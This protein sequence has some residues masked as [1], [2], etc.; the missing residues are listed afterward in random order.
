[1]SHIQPL[2]NA[3]FVDGPAK[4]LWKV[5]RSFWVK[6][7]PFNP[8]I[9]HKGLFRMNGWILN[10]QALE[11]VVAG[12]RAVG[13]EGMYVSF[14][15]DIREPEAM[16]G[17]KDRGPTKYYTFKRGFLGYK[18]VRL[19]D[20]DLPPFPPHHFYIPL[21]NASEYRDLRNRFRHSQIH[22]GETA[23]YSASERWGVTITD[24]ETVVV[25]GDQ[26]FFDAYNAVHPISTNPKYLHDIMEHWRYNTSSW[27]SSGY[28]LQYLSDIIG[29][30]KAR[31]MLQEYG[32]TGEVDKI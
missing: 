3:E 21:E 16:K 15:M 10:S 17:Y 30:D 32:Y 23:L 2:S 12:A 25:G 18:E 9:T 28:P 1:M 26:T 11:A 19:R 22:V 7:G 20:P 29:K 14:V 31:Q 8:Q 13:D 5:F 6:S 24:I 27:W 4:H